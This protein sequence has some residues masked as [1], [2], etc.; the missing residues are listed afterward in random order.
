MISQPIIGVTRINKYAFEHNVKIG[1]VKDIVDGKTIIVVFTD[2]PRQYMLDIDN[3]ED[4]IFSKVISIHH[5]IE[6][7]YRKIK[8]ESEFEILSKNGTKIFVKRIG[9]MDFSIL[10]QARDVSTKGLKNNYEFFI[11]TNS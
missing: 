6:L 5:V 3:Y 4:Y 8:R 1:A 9:D 2:S 11:L 7:N 10:S